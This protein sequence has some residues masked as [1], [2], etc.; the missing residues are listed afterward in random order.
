MSA[1]WQWEETAQPTL[2]SQRAVF[3]YLVHDGTQY[4]TQ[5]NPW[6]PQ[7]MVQSQGMIQGLPQGPGLFGWIFGGLR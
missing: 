1:L 6:P 3:A 4:K 7:S 2:E 5:P